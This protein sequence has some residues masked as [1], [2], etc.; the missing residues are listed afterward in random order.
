MVTTT[1]PSSADM[2]ALRDPKSVSFEDWPNAPGLL[3]LREERGPVEM[4]VSGEIP[5][6]AA[7]SLFRTGPGESEI[8]GTPTGT[9]KI[10]HWFD[11]LGHAHRF[12]IIPAPPAAAAAEL[13]NNGN[14]TRNQKTRVVYTSRRQSDDLVNWIRSKGD[15]RLF[16]FAQKSDPCVGLFGKIMS[17][18]KRATFGRA[19]QV[20]RGLENIAVTVLEQ[21]P[22]QLEREDVLVAKSGS[23]SNTGMPAAAGHQS[24][25]MW[26]LTDT[27]SISLVDKT[28]LERLGVATQQKLHPELTGPFSCAHAARDPITGDIYNYNLEVGPN[29]IYRVFRIDAVDG[30]TEIIA[31]FAHR[32]IEPTYMHSFFLTERHII[33][34]LSVAQVGY[35]GAAMMLR[36]NVVESLAPFDPSQTT[37][38]IFIDRTAARR[39]VVAIRETKATF[40]FHTINAWEESAETSLSAGQEEHVPGQPEGSPQKEH[41]A[42]KLAGGT[43]MT[44]DAA[45]KDKPHWQITCDMVDYDSRDILNGLYYD[46][47]L[48]R[49]G[50]GDAFWRDPERRS[51]SLPSL[52]RYVFSIPAS[53]PGTNQPGVKITSREIWPDFVKNH[54]GLASTAPTQAADGGAAGGRILRIPSPRAG[55]LPIINPDRDRPERHHPLYVWSQ[56]TRGLNTLTDTLV[57]TDMDSEAAGRPGAAFWENPHGHTPGEAIFLPRPR[58]A[59]HLVTPAA[60]ERKPWPSGPSS[61][62]SSSSSSS[63][64]S[65][66]GAPATAAAAVAAEGEAS[67]GLAG[68]DDEPEEDDGCLLSVVLDGHK[69]TSYLVCLD[70]KTM[71]EVG[72]AE[73]DFPIGIGFHGAH[74]KAKPS[75]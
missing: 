9:L 63:A 41:G 66:I 13:E 29:P 23:G 47:I 7:G 54:L 33:L 74:M 46:V 75:V 65:E 28:T 62:S 55:E 35:K 60:D 1:K 44:I 57:K 21:P 11:G 37:K 67:Q 32:A 8:R 19:S 26:M 5:A 53:G 16:S 36:G 73:L 39:G 59:P 38:W 49:D 18:F 69:G 56:G 25:T 15:D 20:S 34:C 52:G 68:E 61:S 31:R 2:F 48:N 64:S 6:W 22:I 27:S 72:R 43:Q 71:V 42:S 30:A 24:N 17:T 45:I 10:S 40:Y 70:A 58:G 50:A 51:N 14:S 3:G 12:D 4:K